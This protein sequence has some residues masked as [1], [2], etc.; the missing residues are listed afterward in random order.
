MLRVDTENLKTARRDTDVN[1]TIKSTETTKSG[2]I[3]FGR[4]VAAIMTVLEII[5]GKFFG[6][7]APRRMQVGEGDGET[8]QNKTR[9]TN[10][11]WK[12]FN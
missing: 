7:V 10:D 11:R 9:C 1:F 3:E 2:S 4:F 5:A 8:K 12:Q 6:R